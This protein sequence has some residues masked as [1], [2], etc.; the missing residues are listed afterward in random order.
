MRDVH[1]RETEIAPLQ[2]GRVNY[3]VFKSVTIRSSPQ[4]IPSFLTP[5][6]SFLIFLCKL[7]K[8]LSF[9]CAVI[10]LKVFFINTV[11]L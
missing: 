1:F 7:K 6:S 3:N 4:A 11:K 8:C 10:M 2:I 9:F 5:H